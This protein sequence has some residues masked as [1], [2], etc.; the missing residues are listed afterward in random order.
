[1]PDLTGLTLRKEFS[2]YHGMA[3]RAAI[4]G[5]LPIYG[6]SP[7]AAVRN[8]IEVHVNYRLRFISREDDA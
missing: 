1:M 2:A 3:W 5:L 8:F 6:S 7:A 4:H